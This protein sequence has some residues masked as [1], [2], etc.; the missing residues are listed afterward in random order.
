MASGPGA[1]LF[2]FNLGFI[3]EH[4]RYIVLDGIDAPA[5]AALQAVALRRQCDGGF[6]Q[7]ANQYVQKFLTDGH[8]RI[9]SFRRIEFHLNKRRL[10]I[11]A[12]RKAGCDSFWFCSAGLQPG[13]DSSGR[14]YS[15]PKLYHYPKAGSDSV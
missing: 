6:A 8:N 5:L 10:Q 7:R 2:R 3:D 12:A 4:D 14:R 9:N 1:A 13:T 11:Q 15:K